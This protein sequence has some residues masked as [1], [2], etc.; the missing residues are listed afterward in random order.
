VDFFAPSARLVVEVDGS[1]HLVAEHAKS[2]TIRDAYLA[3][4]GLKVVRFNSRDV[5]KDRRA[6]VEAIYRII[7]E[8]IGTEIPPHPPLIKGGNTERGP[9]IHL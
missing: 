6:V 4:L 3:S 7:L 5:L 1:Q 9:E 8:R 2:D